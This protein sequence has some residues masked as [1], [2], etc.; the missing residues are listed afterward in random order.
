[1]PFSLPGAG[2][3]LQDFPQEQECS[4][5]DLLG[6]QEKK[7]KKKLCKGEAVTI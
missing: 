6:F 7:F 4:G 2:S 3:I 5:M 1:M